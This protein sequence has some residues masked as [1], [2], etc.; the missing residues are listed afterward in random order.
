M[1]LDLETLEGRRKELAITFSK[2]CLRNPKIK[3]LFPPNKS[4]HDMEPRNHELF[5]LNHANTERLEN[6]PVIYMQ[7]L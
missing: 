4:T 5:H 7:N 3:H 6:S 2:K 1:I